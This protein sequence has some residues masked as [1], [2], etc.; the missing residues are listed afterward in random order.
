M[1]SNYINLK[2]LKTFAEQN[3]IIYFQNK[4]F[5]YIVNDNFLIEEVT[6]KLSKEI[7][8]NFKNWKK[9]QMKLS[10]IKDHSKNLFLE[11]FLLEF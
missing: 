5:L 3:K 8:Q 2:R 7:P 9:D 10:K 11:F 1:I 4:P 6:I